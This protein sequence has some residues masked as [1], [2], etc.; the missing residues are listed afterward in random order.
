MHWWQRCSLNDWLHLNQTYNSSKNWASMKCVHVG[1]GKYRV[2]SLMRV[3][4]AVFSLNHFYAK[5]RLLKHT[6]I[7]AHFWDLVVLCPMRYCFFTVTHVA[8]DNL[9]TETNKTEMHCGRPGYFFWHKSSYY[10]VVPI[11]IHRRSQPRTC[12]IFI[13]HGAQIGDLRVFLVIKITTIRQVRMVP[14]STVVWAWR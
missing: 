9:N 14:A 2:T 4:S 6:N 1:M 3:W 8:L 12:A 10:S 5:N 11:D 13:P 7:K